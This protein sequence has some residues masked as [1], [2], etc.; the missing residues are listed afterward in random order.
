MRLDNERESQNVEDRRFRSGGSGASL[1]GLFMLW[2]LIRMLLQ[3]KFGWAIIAIGVG[4]YLMG[5]DPLALLQQGPSQ[6]NVSQVR[7]D[8]QAVFIKKVLAT[9]EDV[10]TQ[11][12]PKYGKQYRAPVLV[13]YRGAT[14]SGCGYASAQV[15]PFY[16]PV[17]QK[18]YL[19]LGFFDSLARRFQAPGDF[20]QAYVL[21]HEVGHHVQNLMGILQKIHSLQQQALRRGDK[22]KA[23]HLQIPVELQA[24][25][26]AGVWG[27]YTRSH[28]E[29]GD[30]EEALNAASR[31]GDDTLQKQT[32]GYV[33]PDSFTH[34]TSKQRMRWFMRGFDSGDL[35]QCNTFS[36][37]D[38]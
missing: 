11:I 13:L 14:H 12:L 34:G 18:I 15:G 20:A 26:F 25:C 31:I 27:H 28:L 21:A 3:T 30:I 38:L 22:V 36:E 37:M 2:P 33:V 32:Q 16:C 4:A 10:W 23:N 8:S 35:N 1:R 19:D 5:F 17:D 24:D 9:T 29:P 6:S 7:D